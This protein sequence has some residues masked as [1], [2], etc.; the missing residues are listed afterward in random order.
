[1]RQVSGQVH[2]DHILA[3]LHRR[4][5]GPSRLR[6]HRSG[7]VHQSLPAQDTPHFSLRLFPFLPIMVQWQSY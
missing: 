6:Y 4:L 7:P 1:M 3:S 2:G 5:V